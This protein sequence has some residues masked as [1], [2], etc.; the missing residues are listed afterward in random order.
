MLQSTEQKEQIA[1]MPFSTAP[2]LEDRGQYRE[3]SVYMDGI[4]TLAYREFEKGDRF[5]RLWVLE[6]P[7]HVTEFLEDEA[8]RIREDIRL[9][10]DE[11]EEQPL[12]D[13]V[14]H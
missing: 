12:N 8:R 7:R 3:A 1:H 2:K 13:E 10:E 9:L 4:Q 14:T 6:Y 11:D 5:G